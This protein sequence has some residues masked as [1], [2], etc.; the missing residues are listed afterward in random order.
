MEEKKC[1]LIHGCAGSG[2]STI[3]RKL[4]E[5]VWDRYEK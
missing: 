4:E 2:K 5:F 3:S 1:M